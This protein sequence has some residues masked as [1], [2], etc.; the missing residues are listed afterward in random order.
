MRC[1]KIEAGPARAGRWAPLLVLVLSCMLWLSALLPHTSQAATA[2]TPLVLGKDSA[3]VEA[4]PA[5]TMLSDATRTLTIDQ[6]LAA[7]DKFAA[8]QSSYATL[9]VHKEPLWL[10]FPVRQLADNDGSWVLDIDFAVINHVDF[11]IT[12]GGKV[13]QHY[14]T[15]NMQPTPAG[16]AAAARAGRRAAPGA[17]RLRDPGAGRKHRRHDPADPSVA[18]Q[19]IPQP[20]TERTDDPGPVGGHE[21]VP[22]AI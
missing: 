9:G 2:T 13:M 6:V 12:A 21:P 17:G 22:D 7:P 16:G 19:R 3:Q 10:R 20:G 8:P 18:P 1:R 15:G 4:W 14:A 11:Y 5:V